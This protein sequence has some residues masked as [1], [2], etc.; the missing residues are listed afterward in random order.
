MPR[1]SGLGKEQVSGEVRAIYDRQEN[2][3]G[4]VLYNHTVLARRPG[5]FRGFR[6]MWDGL[7]ENALLA[8]RLRDLVNVRVASLIGCGL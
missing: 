5:V 4:S 3:Y 7:E 2:C 6:S 1:V 8:P